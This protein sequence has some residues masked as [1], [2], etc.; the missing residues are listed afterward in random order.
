MHDEMIRTLPD[1]MYV[2]DL[3]NNLISLS[4][5]DSK[6]CKINIESSDIKVFVGLSFC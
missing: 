1:V 4:I 6:G 5:L 3:Q 2:P